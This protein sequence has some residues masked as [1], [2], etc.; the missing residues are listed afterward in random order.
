M[1]YSQKQRQEIIDKVCDYMSEHGLSLRAICRTDKTIPNRKVINDW[2]NK[3]EAFR[4]QYTRAHEDR[5]EFLFE[6][7]NE[8]IEACENDRD[9]IA[10]LKIQIDL[11]KW[12]LS[13]MNP[14]KYGDKQDINLGGEIK[15]SSIVINNVGNTE[16]DPDAI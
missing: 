1:A 16:I 14:K 2:L 6:Q 7:M 4:N 9:S 5:L 13:K 10:K 12:Q 8:L 3:D 15:G 11:I